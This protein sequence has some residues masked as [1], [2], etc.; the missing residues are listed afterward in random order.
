MPFP[1]IFQKIGP[2]VRQKC[3]YTAE[4]EAYLRKIHAQHSEDEGIEEMIELEQQEDAERG[5][6]P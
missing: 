1:Y 5:N 3:T 6:L 2:H 4:A